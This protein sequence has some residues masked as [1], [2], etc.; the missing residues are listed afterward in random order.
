MTPEM[1]SKARNNKA[2]G[3]YDNVEFRI[4]EI[5][6]LPVAHREQRSAMARRDNLAPERRGRARRG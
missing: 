6:R 5:E 3:G 1:V 2:N 4:G